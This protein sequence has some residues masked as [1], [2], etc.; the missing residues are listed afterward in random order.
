MTALQWVLLAVG[1]ALIAGIVFFVWQRQRSQRL[2]RDFGPEY[3]RTVEEAGQREGEA[4]LRDRVE[5]RRS[6]DIRPL[7]ADARARYSDSWRLIQERFVDHPVQA[8]RAADD[9]VQQVMN[10]R[11]Y[12]TEDFEQQASDLSVDHSDVVM[13]YR[14]AHDA[15]LK[16]DR[17][18]AS[19]EELRKA[20]VGYKSLFDRLL[21]EPVSR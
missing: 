12:P 21:E 9:L 13:T 16:S 10:E 20:M 11:G 5:R 8:I 15:S 14:E 6:L 4:E 19:T 7:S 17:G 18:Q 1:I 3:D 2:R